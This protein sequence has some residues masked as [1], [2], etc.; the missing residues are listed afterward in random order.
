MVPILT[1]AVQR[2]FAIKSAKSGRFLERLSDLPREV[3]GRPSE[4]STA[5]AVS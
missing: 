4:W 2:M 3:E 1:S 5:S